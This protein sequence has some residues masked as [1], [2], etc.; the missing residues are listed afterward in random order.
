[1]IRIAARFCGPPSSGNGGYTAGVLAA[2]TAQAPAVEVTLRRPPPLDVDLATTPTPEGWA[3]HHG[4]HLVAEATSRDATALPEAVPA[5]DVA[6]ARAAEESYA[7]LRSHPF[8]G[9]FVC[10]P[11]REPGDGMLLSPGRI[12]AGR[13][14]CTWT[15]DASLGNADG[16]VAAPYVWAALDCPGGWT[17]ALEDRPMVLGRI[18]ATVSHAVRVGGT[19]VV[20]GRLLG[21]DGRKTVTASTVYDSAGQE[22]A[23]AG[24]TWIDVDPSRFQ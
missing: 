2:L 16:R 11:A 19:Y 22:C 18:A 7:G 10:G 12:D 9:C 20:V 6:T 21:T 1:M 23:R 4:D 24:H 17:G 3:L 15:P 8:S 13:T 5:V 14:A